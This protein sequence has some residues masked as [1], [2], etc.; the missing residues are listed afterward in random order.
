MLVKLVQFIIK[1]TGCSHVVVFVRRG[2]GCA[3]VGPRAS[4]TSR[5]GARDAHTK[6]LP[7]LTRSFRPRHP[8]QKR[9]TER[10][11]CCRYRRRSIILCCCCCCCYCC[12][13]KDS[14]LAAIVVAVVVAVVLYRVDALSARREAATDEYTSRTSLDADIRSPQPQIRCRAARTTAAIV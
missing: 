2:C 7:N 5:R 8:I 12:A 14:S 1:P 9:T 10:S 6:A 13:E 4:S 3:V 11:A